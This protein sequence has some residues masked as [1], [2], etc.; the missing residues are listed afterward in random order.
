MLEYLNFGDY[1]E[2]INEVIVLL[3]FLF[4]FSDSGSDDVDDGIS[5]M[6][7]LVRLSRK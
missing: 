6:E 1:L 7:E 5:F 2:R 3:I 4:I